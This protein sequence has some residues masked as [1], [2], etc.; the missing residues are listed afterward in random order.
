[1][2][3]SQKT[4]KI[5]AIQLRLSELEKAKERASINGNFKLFSQIS[6]D[7]RELERRLESGE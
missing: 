6:Q 3:N 7:I 2:N 4:Y 5:Q 1:M